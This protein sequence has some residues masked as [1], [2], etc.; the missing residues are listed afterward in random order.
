[1]TQSTLRRLFAGTVAGATLLSGMALVPTV[2]AY[3]D[4][5]T[6]D[7]PATGTSYYVDC[8]AAPNGDGTQDKPFNSF[9]AAN[10]VTL[11]AGDRLLFKRGTTCTGEDQTVDGTTIKAAL[12]IVNTRG[13][14]E[15]PIVIGDYGDA[16]APAPKLN[17]AGVADVVLLRNSEYITVENLDISNTDTEANYYK[18][19]RR[20]ITAENDN[21]GELNGII[22]R[23]NSIHDIYG[24]KQKDLGGSAAIQL[25]NYGRSIPVDGADKT[26]GSVKSDTSRATRSWFNDVQIVGNTI[27]NVNRSGINMSS[28]FRC[29]EDVAW[30]CGVSGSTRDQYPWTPNRNLY[31][32]SNT[33][34]DIG[35]DGIVVQMSDGAVVEKN[36]LENAASVNGQGSN[37]GIWNWNSDNTLFQFNEVTN[38]KKLPGNNDGTAWDFDYGTRNTVFQYN[39]SH[40]NAGG[41][42]LVCACTDWYNNPD[43]IGTALGGTFRYNLSVNDGVA[44][45]PRDDSTD[46]YR[47]VTLDGITDMN[48]YN[49][50]TILPKGE[51]VT[52]SNNAQNAGVTYN[53]NVIIAQDGTTLTDQNSKIND[54]GFQI[55]YGSNLYVGGDQTQ[56]AKV[57]ENGNQYVSLADY[58]AATGLDLEAVAKGDLSSLYSAKATDYAAGKGRAMASDSFPFAISNKYLTGDNALKTLDFPHGFDHAKQTYGT[59]HVVSGWSAPAVGAFQ[60]ADTTET[61]AVGDLSAGKS[62][63]IDAPGNATLEIK[64]TTAGDAVLEAGLANDRGYA[65]K[66]TG[67]GEQVLH[68]RTSSDVSKLTLTNTGKS[69]A[70]TGISVSTV[71]DQLWDGSFESINHGKASQPKNGISPWAPANRDHS[72]NRDNYNDAK[73]KRYRSDLNQQNAVVSGERAAKLGKSDGVSFTQIDQRNIPAQPGKTYE[74]GFWVTTGA[75]NDQTPSTVTATVRSRKEGSGAGG[76][77][78]QYGT[79]LLN[80]S[81]D[82]ETADGGDKVYVRGTFTVPWDVP[83]DSALWVNI[84]QPDLDDASAAYADNVTLVETAAPVTDIASIAVTKQPAKT[85]YQTGESLDAAGLEVT[86]TLSDDTTRVLD[87]SEYTLLG[88]DSSKAGVVPVT[89]KL[90]VDGSKITRFRVRVQNVTNLAYKF[91]SSATASDVQTKWGTS[92]ASDASDGNLGTNWSNWKDKSENAPDNPAWINWTFDQAYKLGNLEFYVDQTKAEAAPAQFQVQY[93]GEDGKWVDTDL[94]GKPDASKPAEPTVLDLSGLPATKAISLIVTPVDNGSDYPYVKVAEVKIFQAADPLP[95]LESLTATVNPETKYTEGDLFSAAASSL[96]VEGAWTGDYTDELLPSEYTLSAADKDGNAVDLTQPLPAGDLTV[97]V[98][99]VENPEIKTTFDLTVA[100]K[101]TPEP[102][103]TITGIGVAQNPD[104]TEYAVGETFSAEDLKVSAQLSNGT[105]R[106]LDASEYATAAFFDGSDQPVDLSKPFANAGTLTVTLTLKADK[107]ITTTFTVT[108]KAKGGE[109]QP[110]QQPGGDKD[111]TANP[112]KKPTADQGGKLTDS[113]SSVTIVAAVAVVLIL[114]GGIL[115]L[116]RKRH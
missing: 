101:Q 69:G 16:T 9:A 46:T 24:E 85:D 4:E 110:G 40:D 107:T 26:K 53:N 66:T 18:Y 81:V 80:K 92:K 95:T 79:V 48:Y 98:A 30:E 100:P 8:Q 42:A 2:A 38:T 104:K 12:R 65:Q 57:G 74:L 73:I 116:N 83:A 1:M 44:A 113:G 86:A 60:G 68:V 71:Y 34:K 115:L 17:G 50:T 52:F 77:F 93:L 22:I 90:N 56:W 97:T 20:G 108:V 14:A 58:V 76:N 37:A 91:R 87:P 72:K 54:D 43:E 23:N 3:A 36:Y 109:Q 27:T 32:A 35:G 31:I 47:T 49:N 106:D 61:G 33:L 62:V 15:A 111:N 19:M 10:N 25:E 70:V 11:K 41:A 78:S 21:A 5:T 45:T 94:I 55:N 114:A 13:T 67:E 51:K 99:A 59:Q 102:D 82:A 112:N 84:A 103:V 89:V 63:T 39:Y 7:T 6:Q 28:D 96:K 29:R 64:A 75:S 88:F 105:T